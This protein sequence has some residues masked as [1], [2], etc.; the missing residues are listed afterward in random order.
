MNN[1]NK[2]FFTE[3]KVQDM[4]SLIFGRKIF[5]ISTSYSM[6]DMELLLNTFEKTENAKT[7][8]AEVIYHKLQECEMPIPS[9]EEVIAENHNVFSPYI[10]AVLESCPELQE[11]FLETDTSLSDTERFALANKAYT[12]HWDEE[13]EKFIQPLSALTKQ[14]TQNNSFHMLNNIYQ[15]L[16]PYRPALND[17]IMKAH[18][19]LGQTFKFFTPIQ[20]VISQ[21]A[22]T[23]SSILAT[24]QVPSF[25]E[26]QK[27]QLETNYKLWGALG[28]SVIPYAPLK[29]FNTAPTNSKEADKIALPYLRKEGLEDLFSALRQKPL[30]KEDLESAIFC[31]ENKQHKACAML[32]FGLIDAKLIRLQPKAEDK[33]RRRVGSGAVNALETKVN[34]KNMNEYYL[35]K[36]LY[37]SGLIECLHTFF[38]NGNDFCKEPNVI[39]RNFIDHGMNQRRVRRKDCVQLFLALYNLITLLDDL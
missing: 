4:A 30:K 36:M 28:W 11:F 31:F 18:Q 5:Q 26:V 27:Q 37:V 19:L 9:K 2:D 22:N 12:K 17:G 25:S 14:L 13:N 21:Y 29:L 10:F 34:E 6:F 24:I 1:P 32:L 35:Y 7:A 3:N 16:A 39:N 20:D 33:K 38:A 23:L 15:S 8:I